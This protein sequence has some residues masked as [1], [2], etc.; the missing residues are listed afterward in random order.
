MFIYF[1]NAKLNSYHNFCSVRIR[2]V[3]CLIVVLF[4]ISKPH[5]VHV[6]IYELKFS[7]SNYVRR[8]YACLYCNFHVSMYMTLHAVMLP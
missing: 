6:Y 7:Q 3:N 5:Y 1:A 8:L 2:C 4:E